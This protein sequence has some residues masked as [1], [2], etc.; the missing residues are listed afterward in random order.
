MKETQ[1]GKE[2]PKSQTPPRKG[3]S[4]G[5]ALTLLVI[6]LVIIVT[7]W[8]LWQQFQQSPTRQAAAELPSYGFI[9]VELTTDPFPPSTTGMVWVTIRIQGGGRRP[10]EID[11]VT[12]S[13]GPIDGGEVIEGEAQ[14]VKNAAAT[15]HG[16]VRFTRAGR[17][18][19]KV[20]LES[21]GESGEARFTV[22]VEPAL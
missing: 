10:L 6:P 15:F 9:P 20:R 12:Y 17:W 8:L 19:I 16:P 3:M 21:Q 4:P 1:P 13:Y 2:A 14:A 18:W 7:S 11:R 22:P 5:T